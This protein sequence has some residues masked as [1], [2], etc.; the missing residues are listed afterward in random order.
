ML[1]GPTDFTP[2][3]GCQYVGGGRRDGDQIVWWL[4]C[5]DAGHNEARGVLAPAFA[6]QGWT[7]CGPAAATATWTKGGLSLTVSETSGEPAS[8]IKLSQLPG[9]PC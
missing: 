4:D 9:S 3:T 5:G 2:P 1:A 6:A 7:S 8:L